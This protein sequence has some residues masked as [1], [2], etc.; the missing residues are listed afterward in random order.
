MYIDQ[1]NIALFRGLQI[2]EQHV[3]LYLDGK[4]CVS[5]CLNTLPQDSL[6]FTNLQCNNLMTTLSNYFD[7][8]CTNKYRFE[9]KLF[10][11]SKIKK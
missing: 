11:F 5:Q 1:S 10:T 4:V 3:P 8:Q 7:L 6:D 9:Y 2:L